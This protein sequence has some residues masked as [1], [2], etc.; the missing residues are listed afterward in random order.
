MREILEINYTNVQEFSRKYVENSCFH[1]KN[2]KLYE[3]TRKDLTLQ[4]QPFTNVS[5]ISVFKNST[6][7]TKKHQYW[8]LFLIKSKAPSVGLYQ[9]RPGTDIFL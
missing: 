5:K 9:K 1:S 3:K 2:L 4:K 8:N 6:K 7:F